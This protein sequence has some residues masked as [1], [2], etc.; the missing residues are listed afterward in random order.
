MLPAHWA[1]QKAPTGCYVGCFAG[2]FRSLEAAR[3]VA[4]A[5]KKKLNRGREEH[6][7]LVDA[8]LSGEQAATMDPWVRCPQLEGTGH[9]ELH[10]V[11]ALRAALAEVREEDVVVGFPQKGP[12]CNVVGKAPSR[13]QLW[14][15]LRSEPPPAASSEDGG[16]SGV[17][18]VVRRG[19][20]SRTETFALRT[21]R[22]ADG[23]PGGGS[24]GPAG[25]A[26]G[27]TADACGG[28]GDAAALP[29]AGA[30]AGVAAPDDAT[31]DSP[32]TLTAVPFVLDP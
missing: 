17:R 21:R 14:E 29:G 5:C 2:P 16:G 10:A 24:S 12:V 32:A 26:A 7:C 23:T 19:T 6:T 9:C 13:V 1:R 3:K 20:P 11:A 27:A 25:V 22:V 8:P 15:K 28:A 18:P 30:A 4:L 31:P